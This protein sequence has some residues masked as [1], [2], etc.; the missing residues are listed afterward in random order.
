M[1]DIHDLVEQNSKN[2]E[3]LAAALDADRHLESDAAREEA[4][5][6]FFTGAPPSAEK[7]DDERTAERLER[8]AENLVRICESLGIRSHKIDGSATR[9]SE[10]EAAKS[11]FDPR[12]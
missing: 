6:S 7:S 5:K 9:P 4:A 3:T 10:G 8:N 1:S 11:L 2:I 12:R